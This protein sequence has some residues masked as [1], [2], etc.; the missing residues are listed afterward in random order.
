MPAEPSW[1]PGDRSMYI[2]HALASVLN[3]RAGEGQATALLL[4]H[5]F[6]LGMAYVSFSTAASALFLAAFDIGKLPYVYIGSAALTVLI[7]FLYSRLQSRLRFVTLL[8]LTVAFLLLTVSAFRFGLW[9]SDSKWLAF[10]LLFWLRLL[11]VLANLEFWSLAGCL[12]NVRQ[13]KRLFSLVGSGELTANILGG[14]ATPL[15]VMRFGTANLLVVSVMGLGGALGLLLITVRTYAA[16][17]DTPTETARHGAQMAPS[18]VSGLSKSRY[19]VLII[20]SNMLMVIIYSFIDYTFYDHIKARFHGDSQLAMFLGPFFAVVQMINVVTKTFIASRLFSRYGLRVGL[21]LHPLVLIVGTLAIACTGTMWQAAAALFWLVALTKLSDE[22]LWTSIYDPSLLILYQPLRAE[23]RRALQIAV[24]SIF[25]PLAIGISG[26]S[27]LLLG[28]TDFFTSIHLA[29]MMPVMLAAPLLVAWRMTREYT[30]ALM[31]A[32]TRR[33]MEG[34]ELFFGDS[35]S[36]GVLRQKLHSPHPGEALYA[37]DLLDRIEH[38][39]LATFLVDLLAHPHPAVRREVLSRIERFKPAMALDSVTQHVASEEDPQVRAAALRALCAL[40]EADIVEQVSSYLHDSDAGVRMGVTVGL[41]RYGG[42]EGILA[43]GERLILAAH[44]PDPGLRVFA[45]QGLGEVA[46]RDFYQPLMPLLQDTAPEVRRAALTAAG[47]IRHPK[48]WPLV[49]NNLT[50]PGVGSAAVTALVAGGE[51]VLPTL[52]TAFSSSQD[53]TMRSCIARISGRI[54]GSGAMTLLQKHLDVPDAVVRLHVLAALN[55]CGYQRHNGAWP[56]L[57]RRFEAEIADATWT[58]AAIVDVGN[59]PATSLLQAALQRELEHSC[60][61][62]YFLLSFVYDA[63]ALRSAWDNLTHPAAEKRAYALE[64]IDV[65]VPSELKAQLFPLLDELLPEQRLQRLQAYFPQPSLRHD[66]RLDD[67]IRRSDADTTPWTK[68]CALYIAAV[69]S[70]TSCTAAAVA[71]LTASDPVVRETAVWTLAKLDPAVYEQHARQLYHDASP[72]VTRALKKLAIA[73][74]GE[75]VM[76]LTI[77]KVIVLKT[78]TMFAQTPDDILAEVAS[79]LEEVEVRAGDTIIEKDDLGKCMYI[80]FDGQVRVYD[81][82]HTIAHLGER[83]IFG[84]LAVLDPEPRSASVTA[85]TDT[86]LFRLD[87]EDFY[88][89]MSDRIDVVRGIIRVLCQRL[90]SSTTAH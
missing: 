80:I 58:L 54:R 44:A 30:A 4:L 47:K 64:V 21:L 71:A 36:L 13:G 9:L 87:Q 59:G 53:R 31:Q 45:A 83:D 7:G 42:I 6:F 69:C 5:S 73:L 26:L 55:A 33:T 51:A 32:L 37:L 52:A 11:I 27:L 1:L 85:V 39:N 40:G 15:F 18:R 67:I 86:R 68:A 16:Q 79:I 2:R 23:Q 3:I 22:V 72:H 12:F 57:Q 48:L 17:L 20:A 49:L 81:G 70:A 38:E 65:L 50:A 8:P 60:R 88:E 77:E 10:A 35:S 24:Q 89:L 56:P 41:I 82:D 63:Q 28:A 25:G 78:V 43:A 19:T 46:M 66:Q 90:R 75:P 29:Y 14:F 61:R 84:E 62:V 74:Q 76:L 34:V